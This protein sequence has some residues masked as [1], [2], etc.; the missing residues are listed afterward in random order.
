MRFQSCLE[1]SDN[2]RAADRF[3][4]AVLGQ[5][6]IELESSITKLQAGSHT[7]EVSFGGRSQTLPGQDGGARCDHGTH[8]VWW[9]VGVYVVHEEADLE[10]NSGM[11][12]KPMKLLK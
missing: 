12:W 4:K 11:N 3:R 7:D 1:L 2:C 10:V 5:G 8:V 6:T 9:R